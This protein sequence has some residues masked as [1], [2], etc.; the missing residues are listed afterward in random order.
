[1]KSADR[2]L[3]V[4]QTLARHARPMPTMA[5]ARACNVPKSSA[6]NLLNTMRALGF[7]SY[8]PTDHAWGLG[9]SAF[10]VG[11]AYLRAGAM[12]RL[13]RPELEVL[14]NETGAS[15]QLWAPVGAEVVCIECVP[16]DGV[17]AA[18]SIETG[19]R[20]PVA[21]T[22]PGRAMLAVLPPSQARLMPDPS[23]GNGREWGDPAGLEDVR[24]AGFARDVGGLGPGVGCVATAIVARDGLP[25]GAVGIAHVSVNGDHGRAA[26]LSDAVVR[27]AS[28]L[29]GIISGGVAMAPAIPGPVTDD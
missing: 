28:R 7:V 26:Q 3:R 27:A 13:A 14:A 18:L 1:M 22:A 6:H 11:A 29:S 19:T 9:P 8:Y 20:L 23:K 25:L 2:A 17:R 16:P 10:E 12:E 24:A 15:A 5:I 21:G 4:L